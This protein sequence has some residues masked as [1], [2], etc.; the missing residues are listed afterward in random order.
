VNDVLVLTGRRYRD[1]IDEV[2]DR[3]RAAMGGFGPF[4][5]AR[6][7]QKAP[8]RVHRLLELGRLRPE[9]VAAT[10]PFTTVEGQPSAAP[11]SFTAVASTNVETN[12]WVPS[13]WTPI[14]ANSM[15]A[16]KV[17]RVEFGGIFST[18][19]AA[20]TSVWTPRVGQSA[21]PASNVTLGATTAVTMIAS[22]ASV[23]FYGVLTVVIRSLGL[24]AS[25]AAATGN[26]FVTIGNLTTAAAL[27]QAYGGTVASTVDNTAATGL[28]VSQTWGT[29]SANNTLTCQWV[30]PVA[31]L[32]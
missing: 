31:S 1:H 16:G 11:S 26:G 19:S 2:I 5:R 12:L 10:A 23:P 15:M 24:S 30:T 22:L 8:E 18:S 13:I 4:E 32:N 29:N 7:M 14:P 28:I 9:V 27:V 6:L 25:G 21:T 3:E 20:P 17:Y